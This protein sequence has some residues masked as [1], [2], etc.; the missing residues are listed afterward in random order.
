MIRTWGQQTLTGSAQPLFGDKITAA[1][2]N[3]KQ[4]NGFYFMFVANASKYQIGDR[5][6]LGYGGSSPT[7][8]LMVN[9]VNTSTNILSCISEGDAPVSAWPVNTQIVLSIACAQLLIQSATGNSGNIWFGS[10]STV[11]NSGGGSAF[12]E[13]LAGGAYTFGIAQWNVL[14]TTEAWMAGT[15]SDKAGIAAIII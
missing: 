3:I 11:T 13:I 2:V 15:A 5:I 12:A 4:T 10:D 1:F 7:N 8:V 14:R 9:A 6:I